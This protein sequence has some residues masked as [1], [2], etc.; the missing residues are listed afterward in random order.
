MRLVGTYSTVLDKVGHHDDA[1]TVALPCH[2]PDVTQRVFTGTLRRDVGVSSLVALTTEQQQCEG[3]GSLHA[4][5]SRNQ[6]NS[7]VTPICPWLL[8]MINDFV[9]VRFRARA[10][11][12]S[13]I[14]VI[15][16]LLLLSTE[17][18]A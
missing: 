13:A 9:L 15:Y 14:E 4:M 7:L 2:L 3:V 11:D 8:T 10:P 17:V 5:S 1:V 12:R 6:T 16:L 18:I